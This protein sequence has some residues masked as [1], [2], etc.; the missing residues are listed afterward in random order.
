M[1]LTLIDIGAGDGTQTR[2]LM[3]T[4][5]TGY[6]FTNLLITSKPNKYR[7]NTAF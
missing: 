1:P 4:N 2:D 6:Y 3:I 5:Q 7:A